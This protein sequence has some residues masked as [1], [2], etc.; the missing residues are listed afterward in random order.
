MFL[1]IVS[2]KREQECKVPDTYYINNAYTNVIEFKKITLNSTWCR[3]KRQKA[4]KDKKLVLQ[5]KR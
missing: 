3:N 1:Q 4:Q 2:N 5:K